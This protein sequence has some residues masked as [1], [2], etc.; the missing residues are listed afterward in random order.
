[1]LPSDVTEIGASA[2]YW[3]ESIKEIVLP[4]SIQ[5]IGT[6]AFA[7]CNS[8]EN[9]YAK[10]LNVWCGITFLNASSSP[11][12]CGANLIVDG[13]ILTSAIIPEGSS[14]ISSYA[15]YG[16]ESLTSITIPSS[17]LEIGSYAFYN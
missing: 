16:C 5:K 14:A 10:D 15:F 8:M 1:M 2:F 3:C 7:G 17:I 13:E 4:D 11:L 6:Y 9:V 12:Y